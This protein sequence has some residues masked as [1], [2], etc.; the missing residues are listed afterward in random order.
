MRMGLRSTLVRFVK[1][2]GFVSM[3]NKNSLVRNCGGSA[4]CKTPLC[5]TSTNRKYT[6]AKIANPNMKQIDKNQS[7]L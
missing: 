6:V 5:E 3:T 7:G 2:R 1:E 4:L